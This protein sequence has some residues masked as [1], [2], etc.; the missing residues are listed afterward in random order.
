MSR[1]RARA[2]SRASVRGM[3]MGMTRSIRRDDIRL[4]DRGGLLRLWGSRAVRMAAPMRPRIGRRIPSVVVS[5]G[6]NIDGLLN[7]QRRCCD[8]A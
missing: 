1:G 5:G 6:S 8:D 3:G 2:D 4:R 7:S